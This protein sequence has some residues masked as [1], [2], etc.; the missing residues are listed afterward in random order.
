LPT[1]SLRVDCGSSFVLPV[2]YTPPT[3]VFP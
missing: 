3:A 1:F 2:S